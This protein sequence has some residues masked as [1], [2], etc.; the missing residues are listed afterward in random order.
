MLNPNLNQKKQ[1][2]IDALNA[3]NQQ[4][5]FNRFSSFPTRLPGLIA[6][7]ATYVTFRLIQG[8]ISHIATVVVVTLVFFTLQVLISFALRAFLRKHPDQ[9]VWQILI[10]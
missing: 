8:R 4:Q 1:S 5:R 9:L 2:Q 3:I 10:R 6:L 7:P